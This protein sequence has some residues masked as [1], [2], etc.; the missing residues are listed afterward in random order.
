[1]TLEQVRLDLWR[2]LAEMT[3]ASEIKEAYDWDEEEIE[4][5]KGLMAEKFDERATTLF[6]RN[7]GILIGLYALLH[8]LIGPVPITALGLASVL[9]GA[10]L[11]GAILNGPYRIALE[12]RTPS[13]RYDVLKHEMARQTM[14]VSMGS[15]FFV[16]GFMIQIGAA[17]T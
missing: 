15:I 14:L 11:M 1:M 4:E 3:V 2:I 13:E 6:Y 7:G 12:R 9:Y 10:L 17:L 16:A 5:I 8:L